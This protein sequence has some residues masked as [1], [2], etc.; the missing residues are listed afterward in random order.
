[1]GRLRRELAALVAGARLPDEQVRE[2]LAHEW[3]ST[4]REVVDTTL[5]SGDRVRQLRTFATEFSLTTDSAHARDADGRLERALVLRRCVE[6][7]I[8]E[9]RGPAPFALRRRE[10]LVWMLGEVRYFEDQAPRVAVERRGVPAG[11]ASYP[12]EQRDAAPG[13]YLGTAAFGATSKSWAL[14]DPVSAYVDV[15][16]LG[17]TTSHLYFESHRHRFRVHYGDLAELKPYRN[18]LVIARAT[19]NALPQAF[20]VNGAAESWFLY[21]LA[22]NL[23]QR[24]GTEIDDPSGE[25]HGTRSVA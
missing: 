12:G 24:C 20:A 8:P 21:N 25:M 19:P 10:R 16:T 7:E 11:I 23:A 6:G 2:E 9:W 4:V 5:P 17:L 22:A 15:G 13:I 18:A 14:N 1:V 3:A